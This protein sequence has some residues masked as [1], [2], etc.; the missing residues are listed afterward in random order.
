LYVLS[1][2]IQEILARCFEVELDRLDS[3]DCYFNQISCEIKPKRD[4][5]A[6]L[7]C[8]AGFIPILPDGGFFILADFSLLIKDLNAEKEADEEMDVYFNKYLIKKGLSSFPASK[9]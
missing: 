4:R 9:F 1:T 2:L 7:L 6:K 3:P 8:D 5:L